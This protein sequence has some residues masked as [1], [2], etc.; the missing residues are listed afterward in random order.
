MKTS[1]KITIYQDSV[2]VPDQYAQIVT[3]LKRDAQNVRFE[4]IQKRKPNRQLFYLPIPQDGHLFGSDLP[5]VR[6][7]PI[8]TWN[9]VETFVRV[10]SMPRAIINI[11]AN[12][13]PLSTSKASFALRISFRLKVLSTLW[14]KRAINFRPKWALCVARICYNGQNFVNRLCLGVKSLNSEQESLISEQWTVITDQ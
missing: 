11:L 12:K 4:Y 10:S 1:S 3:Q 2:N 6:L 14:A 8:A 5:S 9:A 13:S 7:V